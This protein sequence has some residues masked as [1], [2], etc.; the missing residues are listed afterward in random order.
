MLLLLYFV[1]IIILSIL[2]GY[3]EDVKV[4]LFAYSAEHFQEKVRSFQ[5]NMPEPLNRQFSNWLSKEEAVHKQI[6]R[7]NKTTALFPTGK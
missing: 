6:D 4:E 1:Q 3:A 2:S 7:Q 5:E